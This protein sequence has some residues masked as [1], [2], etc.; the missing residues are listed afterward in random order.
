LKLGS[1]NVAYRMNLRHPGLGFSLDPK[2]KGQHYLAGKSVV[3]YLCLQP[4]HTLLTFTY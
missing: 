3:A 4:N 2:N 1:P